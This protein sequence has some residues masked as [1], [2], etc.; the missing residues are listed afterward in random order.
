MKRVYLVCSVAVLAVVLIT[1]CYR[2]VI[3]PGADPNGPPQFVSFSGDLAP[4]LSKNCALSGCHDA[5]PAHKPV[6]TADKAF[7]SIIN[8][9]YINTL[10][11][12]QSGIYQIVKGGVMPPTGPLKQ[13]DVQKILDWVRNGAPNN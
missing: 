13:S 10:V 1:G 11:P 7:N 8:G 9:G 5:V 3:S 2:D 6:L 4:L 12:N